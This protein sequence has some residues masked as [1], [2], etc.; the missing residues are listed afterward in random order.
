M[1]TIAIINQKGGEGKTTTACELGAGLHILEKKRVLFCDPDLQGD[2]TYTLLGRTK[3]Q[4]GGTAAALEEP[5]NTAGEII[6]TKYGGLLPASAALIAADEILKGGRKEYRLSEALETVAADYDYCIIDTPPALSEITIN[7]LIA[8][9]LIIIPAQAD[10]YSLLGI[11]DL[12][13]TITTLRKYSGRPLKIGGILLT[14]YNART[15]ISQEMT[16]HIKG[17]AAAIGAGVYNTKIR[18]CAALK[19]AKATQTSIFEYSKKSNGAK[20][21]KAFIKEVEAEQ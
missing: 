1:R 21:Y 6:E 12:Y 10:I 11:A 19:E 4:Q 8:S 17:T 16:E 15:V 9:D 14:R 18:E 5:E 3:A 7:A 20:D 2:L 13:Q